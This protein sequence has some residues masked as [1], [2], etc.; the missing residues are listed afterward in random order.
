MTA[1][2]ASA[3]RHAARDAAAT[4]AGGVV[5]AVATVLVIARHHAAVG[6]AAVPAG[7]LGALPGV[8]SAALIVRRRPRT[9]TPA[10]RVTLTRAVLACGVLAAT[11]LGIAA[12]VPLRTGWLL[13]LVVVTLVLDAVDGPVARRTGTASAAGARLDM[14]VDAGVLLVISLAAGSVV[15]WW[16]LLIGAIRYLLAAAAWLR[17]QL[18]VTLPR[19]EF[20]V[21][22]AAGQAVALPFALAPFIAVDVARAVIGVALAL[23]VVS[24]GSEVVIKERR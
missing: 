17:P 7:L 4:A 16:V 22:V 13:S 11:V 21:W 10:D 24:F 12:D 20:R 18:R 1:P 9:T 5:V 15:G 14:E 8:L 6:N 3:E 19:S 2:G 23:L